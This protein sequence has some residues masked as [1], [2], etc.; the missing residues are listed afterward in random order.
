MRESSR[1]SVTAF[2]TPEEKELVKRRAKE[3]HMPVS[4]YVKW[5]LKAGCTRSNTSYG[6]DG[7]YITMQ[8]FARYISVSRSKAR[9]ICISNNISYSMIGGSYRIKKEDAEAYLKE[10]QI[11]RKKVAEATIPLLTIQDVALRYRVTPQ[12]VDAWIR[13][14]KMKACRID[15]KHIRIRPEDSDSMLSVYKPNK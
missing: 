7:G 6:S 3:L 1:S 14:G 11:N 4:A 10:Q 12:T 13:K 2:L 15:G 5:C 9:D 8:E